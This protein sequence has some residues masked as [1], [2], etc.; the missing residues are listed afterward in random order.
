MHSGRGVPDLIRSLR[1]AFQGSVP[2]VAAIGP[3]LVA[4]FLFW[5]V[6]STPQARAL[7]RQSELPSTH[8]GLQWATSVLACV[9]VVV[10]VDLILVSAPQ[11]AQWNSKH[12]ES[13]HLDRRI[14]LSNRYLTAVLA[15][16]PPVLMI[17]ATGSPLQCL[18]V[19]SSLFAIVPLSCRIVDTI[20]IQGDKT[21]RRVGGVLAIMLGV[22]P[23]VGAAYVS[24]EAPTRLSLIGPLYLGLIGFLLIAN[25]VSA[26]FV[27][28]PRL[29]R[30]PQSLLLILAAIVAWREL[31]SPISEVSNPL[32]TVVHG[33]TTWKERREKGCLRPGSNFGLEMRRRFEAS[34]GLQRER[35]EA[36]A[37]LVSAEGGGIRAAYWSALVLASLDVAKRGTL[38]QD[39]ALLSGVS[40]GSLGVAAW[41]GIQERDD[42]SAEA[43][44]L[45]LS[46][47]LGSDFL[48]PIVA[49]LLFL[50]TPRVLLGPL[51]TAVR[52]EHVFERAIADRWTELVA[53]DFFSRELSTLCMPGL[54][55]PPILVLNA[56][57]VRSGRHVALSAAGFSSVFFEFSDSY[58]SSY[59]SSL[60][61]AS[62][63]EAVHV[64]ARFPYLAAPRPLS[65]PAAEYFRNA[66][67]T[68]LRSAIDSGTISEDLERQREADI[69][70]DYH[71]LL[72]EGPTWRQ[73]LLV[74]GGYFDNTGL[75]PIRDALESIFDLRRA[76][77][78][79]LARRP[80]EVRRGIQFEDRKV[81]VLHISNDPEARCDP[82]DPN[83][84]ATISGDAR[85]FQ[86][87]ANIEFPCARD[88][89]RFVRS[90]SPGRFGALTAP[91]ETLLSVRSQHALRSSRSLFEGGGDH[92]SDYPRSYLAIDLSL[93]SA[94]QLSGA[95]T[96][97]R[98]GVTAKDLF[99][100]LPVSP[101]Y[102][103][104]AT[105]AFALRRGR[106]LSEL[107]P[108]EVDFEASMMALSR[109]VN[110]RG[111]RP[112]AE[113]PLGW[114]LGSADQKWLQCLAFRSAVLW[115]R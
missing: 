47:F 17:G 79:K 49:G 36:P 92:P 108:A 75:I 67:L 82:P 6:L 86:E 81:M 100:L 96:V 42:L 77:A 69:D 58:P 48:S 66:A 115:G 10:I 46:D 103:D 53:T 33:P 41:L 22:L 73:F 44:W 84:R 90:F 54:P 14:G 65:V 60:R 45:L 105:V 31:S 110:C 62:V 26:L 27:V 29:L 15:F 106:Q 74:D 98:S 28:V 104:S 95:R 56:T 37:M 76:A 40:G 99:G 24:V 107:S 16:A 1:A 83:W 94:I 72:K 64:S 55:S 52:R 88:V 21:S 113:V 12:P 78:R 11:S 19:L 20:T 112:N 50:D 4:S 71:A 13:H 102:S 38:A 85:Q 7:A 97:S 57:D 34:A 68:K 109:L 23:L 18:G 51:W 111:A 114:T 61:A 3:H 32:I 93:A 39:V 87:L 80:S 43:R 30:V 25:L 59:S 9:F 8:H 63:A 5:Q 89:D 70:R 101:E 35:A 91:L 2:S